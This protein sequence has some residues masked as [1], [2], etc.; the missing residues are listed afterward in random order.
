VHWQGSIRCTFSG[1]VLLG[2]R[3]RRE[4]VGGRVESGVG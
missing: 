2:R 1:M 4:E 3:I